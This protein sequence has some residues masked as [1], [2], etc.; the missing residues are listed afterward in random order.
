MATPSGQAPIPARRLL[1]DR[2][3]RTARELAERLVARRVLGADVPAWGLAPA[4]FAA[5]LRANTAWAYVSVVPTTLACV[6]VAGE[7]HVQAL[8]DIRRF[9]IVRRGIPRLLLD[10]DG[11]VRLMPR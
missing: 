9:A 3:D 6:S 11:T 7:T 10:A 2:T 4:D 8:I 5:A 1:Y